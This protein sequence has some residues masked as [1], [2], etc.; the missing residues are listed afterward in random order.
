MISAGTDRF[1]EA[2]EAFETLTNKK[3]DRKIAARG[4]AR[5]V[6]SKLV[7]QTAAVG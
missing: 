5:L 7:G 2:G 6:R 3:S 1:V 4:T